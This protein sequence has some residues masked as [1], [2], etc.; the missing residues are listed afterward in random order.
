MTLVKIQT[1]IPL[2]KVNF[3]TKYESISWRSSGAYEV[4]IHE[5][6][7]KKSHV[8]VP[9]I[10]AVLIYHIAALILFPLQSTSDQREEKKMHMLDLINVIL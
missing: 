9:L 6:N 1:T 10:N 7:E 8:A 4:L 3:C 2:T 5:K